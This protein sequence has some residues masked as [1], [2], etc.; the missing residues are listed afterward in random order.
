[1]LAA[2]IVAVLTS[3]GALA[4]VAAVTRVSSPEPGPGRTHEAKVETGHSDN[5]CLGGIEDRKIIVEETQI[6]NPFRE[7]TRLGC[8]VD[9]GDPQTMPDLPT[10]TPEPQRLV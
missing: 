1:M 3:P 10:P 6:S 8:E 2:L 5:Y 9:G 4:D 7:T